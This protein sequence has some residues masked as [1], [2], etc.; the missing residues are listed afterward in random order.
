[1]LPDEIDPPRR[2]GDALKQY[3]A[4][5]NETGKAPLKAEATVRA[6]LVAADGVPKS[7]SLQS[8]SP[9][10]A[11]R[12]GSG[13]AVSRFSPVGRSSNLPSV[14]SAP[15]TRNIVIRGTASTPS[16]GTAAPRS[17]PRAISQTPAAV[18]LAASP[19][20]A[21]QPEGRPAPA[22]SQAP[23]QAKDPLAPSNSSAARVPDSYRVGY[24]EYL[25]SATTTDLVA[26]AL[27]GFAGIGGFTLLGAYAG[28]RQARSLQRALLAPVPTSF[29][30]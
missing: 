12:G 22:P 24:A 17:V 25:R 27:P 7:A 10:S 5:A 2:K 1:M 19:P 29:L 6:G 3:E 11:S 13:G 20:V 15:I 21:P 30:L 4:L 8:T 23:P 9:Q 14:P 18:P 28:Y 26:A 16:V